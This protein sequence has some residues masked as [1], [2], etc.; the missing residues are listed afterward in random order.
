MR[1]HTAGAGWMAGCN[2]V[3]PDQRVCQT[4]AAARTVACS[5]ARLSNRRRAP[6]RSVPRA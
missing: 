3:R 2:S 5:R 4:S 1:V 6:P